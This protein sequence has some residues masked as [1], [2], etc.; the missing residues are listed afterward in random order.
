MLL[1][2]DSSTLWIGLALYAEDGVHC[3]Q[4]WQ[5]HNHHTIELA[6]AI[7]RL[8]QLGQIQP[9]TLKAIA[10]A[11]GPGSFT[12]LRIGLAVAKG[13]ALG[14]N[15]PL[16]GIP[17]FDIL[18]AAQPPSA[19][20]MLTVL[21]AGRGKLAYSLY[22]C[23]DDIWKAQTPP[24]ASTAKDLTA[25][26]STPTL[27]IGELDAQSRQV[28][29]RRWKNALVQ[30]PAACLRRPAWLAELAMQR[31]QAGKVDDPLTLAPIYLHTSTPIPEP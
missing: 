8:L 1:A 29:S 20:P 18:A 11:L 6:P 28:F 16:V 31:L 12:S 19:C 17:T 14:L 30:P 5:S 3:E 27:V 9:A 10:V 7:D 4:V 2:I 21:Q 25:Q 26:I 22:Q 24:L 15:I 13:L 23:E